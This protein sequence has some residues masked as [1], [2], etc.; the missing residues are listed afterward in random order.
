MYK[1]LITIIIFIISN[2]VFGTEYKYILNEEYINRVYEPAKIYFKDSEIDVIKEAQGVILRFELENPTK[3][4]IKLSK[5][6]INKTYKIEYFLAKIKNFAIIEV[7][8]KDYAQSNE[9]ELKNWEISTVIA[10]NIES[11]IYKSG[12]GI[13][14]DRLISIGYGEFLPQKNTPNNGGKY[15]NRVDIIILCNINGD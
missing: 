9:N 14:R 10:N 4:Y 6:T 1:F 13:S 11:Y 15:D 8:T 12:K 3:E 7:H 5:N 2:S